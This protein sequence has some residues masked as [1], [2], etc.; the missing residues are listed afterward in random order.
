MSAHASR[1]L[2]PP[3]IFRLSIRGTAASFARTNAV[4]PPLQARSTPSSRPVSFRNGT[5]PVA[6]GFRKSYTHLKLMAK[7][8]KTIPRPA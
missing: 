3:A 1:I 2:S 4:V 6:I 8:G 7:Q 5:L